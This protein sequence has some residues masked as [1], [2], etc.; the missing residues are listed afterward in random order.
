MPQRGRSRHRAIQA[1]V[2]AALIACAT[3]HAQDRASPVTP[4]RLQRAANGVLSIMAYT[5]TPDVTTS[6][7][8]IND[9]SS[10]NPQLSF[11]QF[12]GGF[13]VDRTYRVYLEGNAA[14]ARYDP[15]FTFS[16]GKDERVLPAKWNSVSGTGGVGW[17]FQLSDYWS[18]RPI[19]NFTLGY[20]ASDLRAGQA[21]INF[22]TGSEINFIDGGT[23]RAYGLGGSL[24]ARFEDYTPERELELE[25]RYTNIRLQSYGGTSEAVKG[26]A[27]AENF[28]VWSRMRMPT[29]LTAM[30]R[31]VRYVYELATSNYM[32]SGVRSLGFNKLV[33]LGFGLE[34]DSSAHDIIVSRWRVVARHVVGNGVAGW[35][36]GLAVSF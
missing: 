30:D 28:G 20:V 5:L 13:V 6:S 21:L 33:S 8:S 17:D 29:G 18:L 32:D 4:Q 31:P 10:G 14:Y 1:P 27:T 22:K 9:A 34:L 26:T 11:T 7:L 15:K 2:L 25:A 3:A 36:L 23:L 19:F 12:G 24:M 35:S 16:D